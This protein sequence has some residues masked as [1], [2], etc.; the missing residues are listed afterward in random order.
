MTSPPRHALFAQNHTPPHHPPIIHHRLQGLGAD[1]SDPF[2]WL[3]EEENE[4]TISY[5]K[6]ENEYFETVTQALHPLRDEIFGEIKSRTLETDLSVPVPKGP[7]EYYARTEEGKNYPQ[8]CRRPRDGGDEVILLDENLLAEGHSYLA[9]GASSVS[10][11]HKRLAFSVDYDGSEVFAMSI[12]GLDE[13]ET[14]ES[15]HDEIADTSYGVVWSADS[16]TIFY[17]RTD[18]SMRPYQ[19]FRHRLRTAPSS[20]VLVYQ[21]DDERF[22]VDVSKT[23]D[24]RYIILDV[25]SKTTTEQRIIP[26]D[27][28]EAA[29]QLVMARRAGIEY[30]LDHHDSGFFLVTND[31]RIDFRLAFHEDTSDFEHANWVDFVT[32]Q[33]EDRLEGI[34]LFQSHLILLLRRQGQLEL[35]LFDFA[36]R[37]MTTIAQP[38]A[39]GTIWPSLN[40]EYETTT[41]RYDFTSF[42]T[43]HSIYELDLRSGH[44]TLLKRQE[45]LG[46]FDPALYVSDRIWVKARDG[47]EIPVSLVHLKE[48]TYDGSNPTLLYGYGSYEHCIDPGFSVTRLSLLDRGFIFAIAHV[49]GGGE[50]G[51][52]WYEEGKLLNKRN[53]FWD[54]IDVARF[55][56]DHNYTSPS[57]LVARGGSAGGMLMGVIANEAPELFQA[58]VAEVPFLDCLTT[59]SDPELPLTVTEWEEWGDPLNDRAIYDLMLAYS[60]YDNLAPTDDFPAF[61]V[62]AGMNDPRVS[63]WEPAKW[64]AKLRLLAP[65]ASVILKTELGAGHMGP[66]GRY[67]AWKDEALTLAFMISLTSE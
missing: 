33:D 18:D 41:F 36:S 23:S 7:F 49:R 43:P 32:L 34:E 26:A 52:R 55:L 44:T 47:R 1:R 19:V 46:E 65:Q 35:E 38:D 28:P 66:T 3:R 14:S 5:L 61:Y 45:V 60:P 51:R 17:V 8:H 48:V 39:Y 6:A 16:E 27:T 50:L 42:L 62:T 30:S 54:F 37:A 10:P 29:P 56:I 9:L 24:E 20:D 21:E 64:V 57:K 22:F 12:I 11:D 31:G 2:Y 40:A 13:D 63:Y 15:L 59:I 53:T 4:A 67:D 25:Q 58:I